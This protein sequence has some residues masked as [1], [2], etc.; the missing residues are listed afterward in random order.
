MKRRAFVTI[1]VFVI[2]FVVGGAAAYGQTVSA[3]IGFPFVAGDKAMAAGK[4][5][6]EVT[7]GGQVTLTGPDRSRVLLPVITMLGRHDKD[8]DNE[9]VFDKIDAKLVLSEVWMAGKD[10]LLLVATKGPHEHA[11]LG[12][13]NP[14]K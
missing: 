9:F 10:G 5:S 1:A 6:V 13:S 14:K 3:D 4:Y 11:V 2:A 12:G 7:A 8:A